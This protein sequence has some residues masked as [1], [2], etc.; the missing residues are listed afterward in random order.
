METL[1]Q[2]YKTVNPIT[3]ILIIWDVETLDDGREIY[4]I[5]EKS[6]GF[7]LVFQDVRDCRLLYQGS[8]EY[9]TADFIEEYVKAEIA[10]DTA[11]KQIFIQNYF[12]EVW[13]DV[14]CPLVYWYDEHLK[15]M[16]DNIVW[17]A[18]GFYCEEEGGEDYFDLVKWIG[19]G[20]SEAYVRSEQ[21]LM[22]I[23]TSKLLEKLRAGEPF[24]KWDGEKVELVLSPREYWAGKKQYY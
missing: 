5:Y 6:D 22:D 14:D 4:K 16:A 17:D 19:I 11:F 7:S 24:T 20:R 13:N 12:T 18:E 8:C 15:T 10:K 2:T 3:D 23:H 9:D 21:E 1:E